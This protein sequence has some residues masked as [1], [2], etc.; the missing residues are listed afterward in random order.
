MT[1]HLK[2]QHS[3]CITA[4]RPN[5]SLA[6]TRS[7]QDRCFRQLPSSPVYTDN[8]TI[9]LPVPVSSSC[10]ESSRATLVG[11]SVSHAHNYLDSWA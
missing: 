10:T 9:N 8:V 5:P 2:C 1:G 11:L 4:P 6:S 7:K 3:S